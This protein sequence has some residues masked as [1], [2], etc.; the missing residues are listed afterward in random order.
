MLGL[1]VTG[2]IWVKWKC[3]ALNFLAS[4]PFFPLDEPQC[5][6]CWVLLGSSVLE[7]VMNIPADLFCLTHDAL[8]PSMAWVTEVVPGLSEVLSHLPESSSL[9]RR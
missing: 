9:D 7:E 6:L 4:F 2:R 1:N 5:H 3:L 8:H